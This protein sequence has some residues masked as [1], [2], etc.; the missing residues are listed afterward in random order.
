MHIIKHVNI[1]TAIGILSII[2]NV[3]DPMI[4]QKDSL[5]KM[6]ELY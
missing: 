5:T 4:H 1:G 2:S 6:V 3:S